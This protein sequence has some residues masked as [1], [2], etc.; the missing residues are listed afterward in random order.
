VK[1]A[2]KDAQRSQ[3]TR[4]Q[5]DRPPSP[6][7]P[8]KMN[9]GLPRAHNEAEKARSKT[10]ERGKMFCPRCGSADVFWASGLPQIWSVWDC[11]HCGY[12]GAFIV[13]DGKLADKLREEYARKVAEE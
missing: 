12:R 2:V 10:D 6:K 5:K 3:K 9:L 8:R 13:K 11:R 1:L 7:K 4:L